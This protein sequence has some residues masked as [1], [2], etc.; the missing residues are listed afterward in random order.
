VNTYRQRWPN[1]EFFRLEGLAKGNV[2]KLSSI[3]MGG[4]F[5]FVGMLGSQEDVWHEQMLKD[6]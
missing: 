2:M 1:L 6:F 3:A 4:T 5:A